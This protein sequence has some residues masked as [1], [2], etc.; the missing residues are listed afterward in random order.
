[1]ARLRKLLIAFHRWLGTAF[2]LLFAMWFLSGVAMMYWEYPQ[3]SDADRLIRSPP[4]DPAAIHIS[5]QA[6]FAA[7][8]ADQVPDQVEIAMLDGRPAY[9]FRFGADQLAVYADTGQLLD[10]VPQAM[11]LRIASAWS[12]RSAAA[13]RYQGAL[14]APD[15]WTVSG[16]FAGLRPLYKFSW[17]EGDE[18]Y[19]SPVTAE[20]V[21][22]TTR[23]SRLGAWFGAI[24]HWLYFTPLRRNGPL[25][26]RIVIWASGSGVAASLLG[27]TIG[28][29]ISLSA[30]RVPYKG[31]KRWHAMLG[32]IFGLI[33]CTWAFS[34]MLSMDPFGWDSG[35]DVR[36]EAGALAGSPWN[37]GAFGELPPDRALVKAQTNGLPVVKEM[38]LAFFDRGPV[39]FARGDSSSLI[40]TTYGP[41]QRF[42]MARIA[43]LM[44]QSS[45]GMFEQAREVL[46]YEPYY[47]DRHN[48]LPLPALC[49]QLNDPERTMFYI[50]L[51]TARIVQSYA[52]TSRWNRWLYHGLHSMDLPWLYRNRPAWDILVLVLLT[53]GAALSITSLILAW[54]FLERKLYTR[55]GREPLP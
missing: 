27:L 51:K 3:V 10:R 13:A 30:R 46:E 32:L 44:A 16:E 55:G 37:A 1:M 45:H 28:L 48:R 18:V 7:L 22:A 53:G 47:I 52:R 19:V 5:P 15:Q 6:A 8:N 25:W 49:V 43:D 14:T 20:V 29:W 42:D 38:E 9:R 17:P 24:P 40:V 12:G 31:W 36:S 11:A 34:G 35:A 39:Y 4:L 26:S 54:R 23:A 50:D 33:T 2:C 21:Q 41:L